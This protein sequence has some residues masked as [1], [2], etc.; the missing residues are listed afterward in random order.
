MKI[1]RQSP[2]CLRSSLVK[3]TVKV[4]CEGLNAVIRRKLGDTGRLT[5]EAPRA[6]KSEA[7]ESL[8]EAVEEGVGAL[9]GHAVHVV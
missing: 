6:A 9:L 7:Q 8:F 2:H 4:S 5:R 3:S 1:K